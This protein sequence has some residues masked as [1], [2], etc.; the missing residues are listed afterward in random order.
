[1][2]EFPAGCMRL[3]SHCHSICHESGC[4]AA[5]NPTD[6]EERKRLQSLVSRKKNPDPSVLS[7]SLQD[8]WGLQL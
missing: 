6:V 7:H 4:A 3:H 1:M 2:D 5:P 8:L